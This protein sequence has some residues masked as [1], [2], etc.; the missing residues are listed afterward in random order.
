MEIKEILNCYVNLDDTI[1][2]FDEN[3]TYR[4][5]E[6]I[7]DID[8]IKPIP[9]SKDWLLKFDFQECNSSVDNLIKYTKI[10]KNLD[11]KSHDFDI[12]VNND[13]QNFYKSNNKFEYVHLLQNLF[14]GIEK[15]HLLIKDVINTEILTNNIKTLL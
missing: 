15:Q 10:V 4:L 2:L 3:Q 14:Y 8:D 11:G 13:M 7:I 5:L 12:Y 1:I 6:C 9:I